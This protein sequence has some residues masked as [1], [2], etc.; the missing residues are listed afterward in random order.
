VDIKLERI[1]K[2][3]IVISEEILKQLR[4][5]APYIKIVGIH[6]RFKKGITLT[7]STSVFF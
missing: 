4:N 1:G 3:A 5:N 6:S 2:K 7:A